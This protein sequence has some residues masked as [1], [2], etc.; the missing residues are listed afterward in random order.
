MN[1]TISTFGA[2]PEERK[3]V[4]HA[5]WV[6]G[7]ALVLSFIC[8]GISEAGAGDVEPSR[9]VGFFRNLQVSLVNLSA[10]QFTADV[11]NQVLPELIK[12]DDALAS[13]LGFT[14]AA[15][16]APGQHTIR[17]LDPYPLLIIDLDLLK[18]V[19][20]NPPPAPP[21]SPAGIHI[22]SRESNWL[23]TVQPTNSPLL[24]WRFL[25]P[26]EVDGVVR[27]SVLLAA[28]KINPDTQERNWN[29]ER[30]GSANLIQKLYKIEGSGRNYFVIWVPALNRYYLGRIDGPSGDPSFTI[31]TIFRDPI[32]NL[33]GNVEMQARKAFQIL[34]E[35]EAPKINLGNP[36]YPPR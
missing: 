25:Y 11:V 10:D 21:L 16:V 26:I 6:I 34:K 8:F 17:A 3:I 13:R 23:N 12:S 20:L 1:S 2:A 19:V 9:I 4:S 22:L 27:S 18:T 5:H 28:G 7:A 36:D 32:L 35:V 29:I 24:T 14:T 33:D 15:D 31:K 30:I